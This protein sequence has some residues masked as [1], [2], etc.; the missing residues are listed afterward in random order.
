MK[1]FCVLL[2]TAL[3]LCGCAT[4]NS[5]KLSYQDAPKGEPDDKTAIIYFMRQKV[6]P[7]MRN[8][9]ILINDQ[10][11]GILP[12][13][14]FFWQRVEPGNKLIATE[15]SWDTGMG[16]NT[17]QIDIEAAQ[18]YYLLLKQTGQVISAGFFVS[19]GFSSQ[20]FVIKEKTAQEF[21][22]KLKYYE[23]K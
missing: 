7:S 16:N 23:Q 12:N 4:S 21:F 10:K 6:N 11:I 17:L 22:A 13:N 9:Q 18:T 8:P 14:S 1:R 19:G 2:V 20:F 3:M 5:G 15:W